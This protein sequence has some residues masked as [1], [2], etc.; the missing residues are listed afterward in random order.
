MFNIQKLRILPHSVFRMIDT[1]NSCATPPPPVASTVW[2]L[3]LSHT[4]LYEVE[5][6]YSGIIYRTLKSC[7]IAWVAV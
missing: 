3:Q 2:S 7:R 1:T 6:D 5:T 4:V